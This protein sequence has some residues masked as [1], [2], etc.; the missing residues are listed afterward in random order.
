M[1]IVAKP[2]SLL[3]GL[4]VMSATMVTPGRAFEAVTHCGKPR[5]KKLD[6]ILGEQYDV[7]L[8]AEVIVDIGDRCVSQRLPRRVLRGVEQGRRRWWHDSADI[9]ARPHDFLQA[10]AQ[11]RGIDRRGNHRA[12]L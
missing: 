11:G 5:R 9:A 8:A 6:L 7:S 1:L 12:D 2:P 4:G 3:T 10:M